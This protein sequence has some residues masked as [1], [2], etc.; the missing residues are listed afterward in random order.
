MSEKSN[1]YLWLFF[2]VVCVHACF[3]QSV[4]SADQVPV[5][6]TINIGTFR[7]VID[8][9][10]ALETS[11]CGPATSKNSPNLARSPTISCKLGDTANE[12]LGRPEFEFVRTP[13]TIELVLVSGKD[14]GFRPDSQPSL[15]EIYE[16]AESLG[17]ALCPA[18]VG[19]QL[20]LQYTDQKIGEFLT[21][22]MH[23][24]RDYAGDL[25]IL[26]LGNGGTGLLLVGG[27]GNPDARIPA[28]VHFVFM[29]SPLPP[30]RSIARESGGKVD[31]RIFDKPAGQD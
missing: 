22:A 31:Q 13:R 29:R 5:W 28:S 12:I 23:P 27:R 7:S 15:N 3:A 24:I 6:K 17:F 20:R 2:C 30:S 4:P 18:E 21:I 19:P 16:R 10:E 11:E 9:R 25:T 1:A 8:L 26:S 14:I